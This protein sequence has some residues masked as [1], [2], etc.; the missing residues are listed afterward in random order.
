[1]TTAKNDDNKNNA[2]KVDDDG[3]KFFSNKIGIRINQ[4]KNHCYYSITSQHRVNKTFRLQ[5]ASITYNIIPTT[6]YSLSPGMKCVYLTQSL[7]YYY[8]YTGRV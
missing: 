4:E 3:E 8:P 1:M 6:T 2:A 5:E 7:L